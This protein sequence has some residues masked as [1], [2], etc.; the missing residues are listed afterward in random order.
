MIKELL[1]VCSLSSLI[2]RLISST[3]FGCISTIFTWC[4]SI[5]IFRYKHI[6]FSIILF[7]SMISVIAILTIWIIKILILII[8]YVIVL[9][10]LI[11]KV[12]INLII[13]IIIT[14]WCICTII[15]II[16]FEINRIFVTFFSFYLK[17]LL[18]FFTRRWISIIHLLINN[19]L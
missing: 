4:H 2:H 10:I 11:L 17:C 14:K 15:I 6:P 8:L 16:N 5:Y 13:L 7:I 1:H 19:F 18:Y 3:M 12:C 9:V